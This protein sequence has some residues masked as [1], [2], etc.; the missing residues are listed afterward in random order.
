MVVR[1][2]RIEYWPLLSINCA[3]PSFCIGDFESELDLELNRRLDLPHRKGG[4]QLV[5]LQL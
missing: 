1:G 2:P 3:R 5:H 4:E